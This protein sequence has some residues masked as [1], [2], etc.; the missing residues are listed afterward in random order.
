MYNVFNLKK[1]A[2]T[3]SSQRIVPVLLLLVVLGMV[4]PLSAAERATPAA[5]MTPAAPSAGILPPF[6]AAPIPAA[7]LCPTFFCRVY[8]PDDCS[9]EW[10]VCPNGSVVCGV[11]DGTAAMSRSSAAPVLRF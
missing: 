9:C 2:Q 8:Y 11:W 3:M 10:I 6:M 4:A 5:P 1:G 7:S